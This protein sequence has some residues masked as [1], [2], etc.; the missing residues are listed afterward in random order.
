MKYFLSF[1]K[2]FLMRIKY[3]LF[4]FFKKKEFTHRPDLRSDSEQSF[5]LSEINNL[6]KNQ[7]KFSY[8][9]RN[10]FIT[11]IIETVDRK[12]GA[13]YLNILESRNDGIL[14]K[15][16]ESVIISD[17]VGNPIK[18]KY[19]GYLLPMAP[20]TLRYL[21]ITSDLNLL[22]GNKFKRV[23][24]IGC[25]YGG[26]ALVN[27]QILNIELTKL[28]DLPTVNKLIDRYLNSHLLH[29][30]FKTTS[31][32]QEIPEN[33][34]LVISN[35]AFSEIPK[36]LQIRYIEKVLSKSK[37]GYLLMNTGINNYNNSK[38]KLTINELKNFL[39]DIQLFEETPKSC[40]SNYLIIWGHK[41]INLN[42]LFLTKNY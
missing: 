42:D 20:T 22:F 31:L 36:L 5:F 1:L 25:G 13:E 15:G 18:Y 21:K 12:L 28:F 19:P 9:K 14:K 41:K 26:Q 34:D 30:S 23:A 8:F 3:I 17:G 39:P 10:F 16:L 33:Y 29:G 40:F 11:S 35:Y 37:R 27:D 32:N 4:N 24:E 6:L 2:K 7:Q 38:N